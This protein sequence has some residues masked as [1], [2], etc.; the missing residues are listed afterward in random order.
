MNKKSA[1]SNSGY[2]QQ[3]QMKRYN[4]LKDDS[5]NLEIYNT[6]KTTADVVRNDS[7]HDKKKKKKNKKKSTHQKDD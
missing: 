4:P 1:T 7:K 5:Y 3:L 2:S 6:S